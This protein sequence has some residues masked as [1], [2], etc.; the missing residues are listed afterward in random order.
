MA[1]TIID[2]QEWFKASQEADHE[3]RIK[4]KENLRFY[5]GKQWDASDIAKLN[6]EKRPALTINKI[7][8]LINFL[9]GYIIQ[10]SQDISVINRKGATKDEA[11]VLTECI[12][13]VI[14]TSDGEDEVVKVFLD[15]IKTGRGFLSGR[16]DYTDDPIN[17]DLVLERFN[18]LR[19]YP[20]PRSE[21]YDLSDCEFIC[22]VC[23]RTVDWVKQEFPDKVDEIN[24]SQIKDISKIS[25]SV[26]ER[27]KYEESR[28]LLGGLNSSQVLVEEYWYKTTEPVFYVITGIGLMQFRTREEV[29]DFI[30]RLSQT[31]NGGVLGDIQVLERRRNVL[32]LATVVNDVILQDVSKP[33]GEFNS[34]PIIPYYPYRLDRDD[35]V[36]EDNTLGIIDQI[37]DLQREINKRRSQQLHI[38]NTMS[39]TGWFNPKM[40]GANKRQLELFGSTPGV[41]IEYDAIKPE[42]II[43]KPPS[44]AHLLLEEKASMDIKENTGINPDLLGYRAE[45]GE[46]GI[47]IQ[48]R[49]QQGMI[50]I[51]GVVRNFI[52]TKKILGKAL[53]GLITKSG[54]YSEQEILN[55]IDLGDTQE[56]QNRKL[57]A[58]KN[59]L[60]NN[61]VKKFDV[62]VATQPSSPTQR[63]FN[64]Y[65]LTELIRAG[66]PIPPNI[67]IKASDVPYQEEILQYIK[68]T[69]E[70]GGS[71]APP[72]V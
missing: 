37:K 47:V 35:E 63:I 13:H 34:F 8:P 60:N 69:T 55:I 61:Q 29:S 68:T 62:V 18:P 10:N 48:M 36:A 23:W 66:I 71:V 38:I 25:F 9:H 17:G 14:D 3:W 46:P 67:L 22:K 27:K 64:F 57:Q 41:V 52:Q 72:V 42:P 40:G 15:G 50:T 5:I 45:R 44:Q 24:V 53:I 26:G 1:K 43:P 56:E 70:M 6:R 58:V 19:I 4:A 21:K 59:I 2:F 54:L 7:F 16:V 33:L 11:E 31:G 49:Q 65:K 20:D 32:N 12:K 39:H 51:E 30:A 28:G